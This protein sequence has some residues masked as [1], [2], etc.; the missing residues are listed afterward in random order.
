M[1]WVRVGDDSVDIFEQKALILQ[2]KIGEQDDDDSS[3]ILNTEEQSAVVM[4]DYVRTR[5]HPGF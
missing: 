1:E 5:G 2:L 4:A 3:L